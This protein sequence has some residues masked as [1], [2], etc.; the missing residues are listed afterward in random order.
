[1][2]AW[3]HSRLVERLVGGATRTMVESM[4]VPVLFAH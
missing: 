2:G 3:G 4:T 1:M